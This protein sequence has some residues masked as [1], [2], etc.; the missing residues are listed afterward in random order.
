MRGSSVAPGRHLL[1]ASKRLN[2]S[3]ASVA[4]RLQLVS[5]SI[6]NVVA[7]AK[8]LN[9]IAPSEVRFVRPEASGDFE[10][11]WDETPDLFRMEYACGISSSQ[12]THRSAEELLA[13]YD[14]KTG[15]LL[16]TDEVRRGRRGPL[17]HKARRPRETA[18]LTVDF[19]G[20]V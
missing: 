9:G 5:I 8:M 15:P 10:V 14:R 16:P 12:V 2:W 19:V 18:G 1:F 7:Y 20:A 13:L 3:A 4:R 6:G 17:D 11:P